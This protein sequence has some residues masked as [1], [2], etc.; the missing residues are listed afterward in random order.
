MNRLVTTVIAAALA[1]GLQIATAAS[2]QDKTPPSWEALSRC[3]DMTDPAKE[4]DCYRAAMRDA[5]YVRN[6][7]VAAAERHK[8]FGLTLPTLH[9]S[10]EKAKPAET[11]QAPGA[12]PSVEGENESRISVKIVEVAYTRPL[13]QLLIVTSDGGVWEQTDTIPLTFTPRAGDS[14]EIRK[15]RFGGYFC[16]FDRT[17]AV[18][19]E[20]KN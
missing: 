8:T 5:G 10:P 11:A 12:A 3:A 15:T 4:L 20:R 19:C 9:K 6:P 13:N 1:G 2:A 16:K 17:N 14:L 18:R 7:Q